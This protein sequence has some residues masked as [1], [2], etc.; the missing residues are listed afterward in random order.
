[1]N[2]HLELLLRLEELLLRMQASRPSVAFTA[3]AERQIS[4]LRHQV[5][6]A[7]LSRFDELAR[8]YANPVA[9]VTEGVCQGCQNRISHRAAK[10][11]QR[12]S[13]VATCEACGRF[14]VSVEQIPDFL[15]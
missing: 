14:L 9:P 1:M 15:T 2:K 5:P 8:Q 7:I 13:E 11:V 12:I 10:V 4:R 6:G 3:E